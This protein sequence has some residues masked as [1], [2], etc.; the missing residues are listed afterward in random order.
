KGRLDRE[1]LRRALDRIVARHEALRTTV[2]AVE[3]EPSQRIAAPEERRV[4]LAER[5]L[6]E[7]IG[8]TEEMDR[9][10]REEAAAGIDTASGPLIRGRLI[11]MG[12]E[13]HALLITMHHI[14]S[15][16]WSSDVFIME[17]SSLY[18]A[19]ARGEEDPLP[20]LGVQY[21]DYAV[22]QR[23]WMEGEVLRK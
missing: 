4:N 11:R 22:W 3:G 8:A 14:V 13:E 23:K 16:G 2:I 9:L 15:D 7:Q 6:R 17:L 21:A 19:F 5:D 10:V 18:R 12:E 20:E 1:A